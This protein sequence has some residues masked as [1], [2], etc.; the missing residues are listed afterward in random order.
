MRGPATAVLCVIV[1]VGCGGQGTPEV[2]LEELRRH[3]AGVRASVEAR[4]A[5]RTILEGSGLEDAD[6]TL[7]LATPM[8]LEIVSRVTGRYLDDV[9]LDLR[10]DTVVRQGADVR[11]SAGPVRVRAGRWDLT[12]TIRRIRARLAA[13]AP[14]VGV[15]ED[16]QGLRITLPVEVLGGSGEADVEFRW[17]A[18]RFAGAV[19]RDFE[20]RERF[21]ATVSPR[22]Y[23][24]AGRLA[25]R[26][27][28]DGIVLDPEFGERR[29]VQPEPTAESWRRVR[30]LLERQD[31]IFRCGLAIDADDMEARLR[32]LLRRGFRFRLPDSVLRP[33]RLPGRVVESVDVHG[34]GLRVVGTAAGLELGPAWLWYGLDLALLPEE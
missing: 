31:R 4:L 7:R 22:G 23:T 11:V 19:C 18:A 32:D 33:I 14:E 10:P 25:L 12:L 21:A 17:V 13:R 3:V 24:L 5:T 16:I 20:V 1:A 8:L 9:D 30:E 27:E 26:L 2:E 29:L 6:V 34:R 28:G 15:A